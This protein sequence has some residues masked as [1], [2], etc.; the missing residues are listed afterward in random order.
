MFLPLWEFTG[1]QWSSS[2]Y[3]CCSAVVEDWSTVS[4]PQKRFK[5][6]SR[7][8][9]SYS[10]NVFCVSRD[11]VTAGVWTDLF[12]TSTIAVASNMWFVGLPFNAQWVLTSA[13]DMLFASAGRLLFVVDPL[14]CCLIL[15]FQNSCKQLKQTSCCLEQLKHCLSY[16]TAWNIC[17][18][19]TVYV[20]RCM[21]TLQLCC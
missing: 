16:S 19:W 8:L 21:R 20:T 9:S 10:R 13:V 11:V 7:M 12:W 1:S 2:S 3:A 4:T 15:C 17:H 5:L 18:I 6:D 14:S